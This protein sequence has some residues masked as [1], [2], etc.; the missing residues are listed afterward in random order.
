MPV[1]GIDAKSYYNSGTHAT[2]TWVLLDDVID[3]SQEL[4]GN[5]VDIKSRAS[6][7]MATLYGMLKAG[8][9]FTFLHRKGTDANR[10]ILLAIITGRTPKEFAFMD[11]AIATTGA[12]GL[13]SYMN[14]ENMNRSEEIEGGLA[15]DV[16]CK[17]AYFME[18]NVKVDPDYYVVT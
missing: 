10:A 9:T 17:T 1:V 12:I 3:L 11:Q 13:R 7:W 8:A 18:S 2:P 4:G 16:A 15:Y 5:L 14:L 6:N